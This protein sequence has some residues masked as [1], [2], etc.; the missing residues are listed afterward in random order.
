[1]IPVVNEILNEGFVTE[2]Q[3]TNTFYLD[4]NNKRVRGMVDGYD[5]MKQVIYL[6]L[7]T[8]RFQYLIFSW[9]YGVEFLTLFGTLR[10]FAVP[11]MQ[12]R[13]GEALLQDDRIIGIEN[14]EVV[15]EGNRITA[16]FIVNTVFGGV[17]IERSVEI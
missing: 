1:M 6:I 14:F 4:M 10:T 15:T 17:P 7:S 16:S 3:P 8:E 2:D 5:A 11:E 12:R 9:N 13:I